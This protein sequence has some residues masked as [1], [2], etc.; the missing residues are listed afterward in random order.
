VGIAIARELAA[1][2]A[3]IAGIHSSSPGPAANFA[4]PVDSATT[5][6]S[7]TPALT[8]A[9]ALAQGSSALSS[10]LMLG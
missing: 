2:G 5:D 10:R 1:D 7:W 9:L 8:L 6:G 3:D 4:P